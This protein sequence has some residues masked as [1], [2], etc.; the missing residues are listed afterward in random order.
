MVSPDPRPAWFSVVMSNPTE[1]PPGNPYGDPPPST[2]YGEPA[3][4]PPYGQQPYGQP[5]GQQPYGQPYGQQPY[6]AGHGTTDP[7]KRPATVTAASIITIVFSALSLLA[8]GVLAIVLA[9]ARDDIIDEINREMEGQPGFEDISADDL[10]N[11]MIVIFIVFAIWSLIAL[12]TATLALRRQNW[13]R[14]VTVISAAVTAL[15]SLLSITSGISAI[16]LIAAVAV[17]VLYFTGGASDWYRRSTAS[18]QLPPGTTQP[19]G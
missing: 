7:D 17:I 9:A 2:P 10:A 11:V 4:P 1:P 5:Y 18:S 3:Q 15:F 12:V 8:F 13:A 14:I 6:G 16:T 19:W